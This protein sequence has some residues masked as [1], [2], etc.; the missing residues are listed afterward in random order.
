MDSLFVG[1]EFFEFI[2]FLTLSFVL[3]SPCILDTPKNDYK[4][5]VRQYI[6]FYENSINFIEKTM[7]IFHNFS[8]DIRQGPQN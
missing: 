8:H 7:R 1:I 2:T 4:P 3:C 5:I 6:V